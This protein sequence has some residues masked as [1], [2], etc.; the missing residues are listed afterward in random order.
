MLKSPS[1]ELFNSRDRGQPTFSLKCSKHMR[2]DFA[3]VLVVNFNWH[4]FLL[5]KIQFILSQSHTSNSIP[6]ILIDVRGQPGRHYDPQT[7][8]IHCGLRWTWTRSS[9]KF[10]NTRSKE[11]FCWNICRRSGKNVSESLNWQYLP[12][13]CYTHSPGFNKL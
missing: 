3:M 11:T 2:L 13:T 12:Q 8:R 1:N 4:H 7:K 10:C 9:S 6:N 5:W